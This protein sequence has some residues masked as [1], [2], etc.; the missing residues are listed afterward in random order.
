T[1]GTGFTYNYHKS[2]LIM[3]DDKGQSEERLFSGYSLSPFANSFMQ[4]TNVFPN[5][6][7]IG[8]AD[9]N[10]YLP[11]TQK[12]SDEVAIPALWGSGTSPQI[13]SGLKPQV[14]FFLGLQVRY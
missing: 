10:L 3:K 1:L 11:H 12:S 13:S 14:S 2:S 7:L 5:I 8:G 6:D 4:M 9:F